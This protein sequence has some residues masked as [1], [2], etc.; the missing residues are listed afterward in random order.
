MKRTDYNVTP[1]LL[2]QDAK[3]KDYIRISEDYPPTRLLGYRVIHNEAMAS[4][5]EDYETWI[6]NPALLGRQLSHTA[7]LR[8]V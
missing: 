3:K 5:L 1:T 2:L 8:G 7:H 6:F 4:T